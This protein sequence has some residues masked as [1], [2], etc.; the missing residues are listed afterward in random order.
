M[1]NNDEKLAEGRVDRILSLCCHSKDKV[2]FSFLVNEIVF[3]VYIYIFCF[4]VLVFGV[5]D[6]RTCWSTRYT[7]YILLGPNY[8]YWNEYRWSLR[9]FSTYSRT[10]LVSNIFGTTGTLRNRFT[11]VLYITR[12]ELTA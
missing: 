9:N 12:A 11:A 7:Y 10:L 6:C 8:T 2:P 1:P 5:F 3:S 4:S